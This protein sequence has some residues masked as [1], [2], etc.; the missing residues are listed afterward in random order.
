MSAKNKP[1][2]ANKLKPYSQ[3]FK[4]EWLN[5]PDFQ[6]WLKRDDID[7]N[8]SYCKCCNTTLKNYN[9]S[10]LKKHAKTEKHKSNINVASASSDIT[11]FLE[12]VPD[13]ESK[14]IAKSE[15]IIA[16][17][18]AEHNIPFKTVDHFLDMGKRVYFDSKIAHKLSMKR[19]KL[20]YV[21]QDGNALHEK[22]SINEI[23]Q[24]QKFSIIVDE[25]TD[26]SVTQVG[27]IILFILH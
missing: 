27:V 8:S 15:L 4:Q 19:T 14:Q 6:S 1:K 21:M 2:S 7:P 11:H 26:I 25:S 12:K 5:E 10:M 16:A 17:Y 18:F 20:T 9:K 3:S 24:T 13:N 22:K 23:C